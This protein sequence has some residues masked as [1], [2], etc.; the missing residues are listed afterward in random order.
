MAF[1]SWILTGCCD[2]SDSIILGVPQQD[3]PNVYVFYD[4]TS[5]DENDAA[6][7]SESIRSWFDTNSSQLGL[8]YEGVI[9]QPSNNGENYLW[10]A[11]YPYLGS[12]TGGTLSDSTPIL[13]FDDYVSG[14]TYYAGWCRA[15][16]PNSECKPKTVEFN[17]SFNTGSIY[18][19]INRGNDLSTGA[20]DPRSQGV[21]FDHT[22]LNASDRSGPGSFSGQDTN[23]IV[24]LVV[25]E[26]DGTVGYY[27]GTVDSLTPSQPSP[28]LNPDKDDLFND[29]FKLKGNGYATPST[30][31]EPTNRFEYDYE[32]YLRVWE[33]IKLNNGSLN[34]HIYPVCENQWS[35]VPFVQHSVAVVEGTTISA[36][37]FLSE[38]GQDITDVG[39]EN[40]NLSALTHTN[41]YS[42]LT[43]TTAYGNLNPTY[44]NGSGL[45]NFGFSVD[46][47]VSAFTQS[48]VAASLDEF[49][50][51]LSYD[52]GWGTIY[53]GTCYAFSQ[54]TVDPYVD[55]IPI[56][57][58]TN[59]ICLDPS[60][61]VG[62]SPTPTP[63][64]TAT[65]T[66]TPS[67]T[68]TP[69]VTPTITPT[70]TP[71]ITTSVQISPSVTPTFT[72]TKSITPT[73]SMGNVGVTGST[74]FNMFNQ[75]FDCN[76]VAKLIGCD[77]SRT[78]YVN[79]YLSYSGSPITSGDT[80]VGTIV[81]ANGTE[82]ICLYY[83]DDVSGSADSYVTEVTGIFADCSSC[84]P[85]A[86]PSPT[87]S[88]TPTM[89]VTPSVT[90]TP[91]PTPSPS[92][93]SPTPVYVYSA[94]TGPQNI[95]G[96]GTQVP[97]VTTGQTFRYGGRCWEY[98][99]QF[100][101]PYSPPSGYIYSTSATN[102]FGTPSNIY[103]NCNACASTPQPSNSPT[104]T[105]T[106]S[107]VTCRAHTVIWNWTH[108]CP[109]CD[110]VGS[111]LTVYT[112]NTTTVLSDGDTIYT[113]CSRTI[114]VASGRFIKTSQGNVFSVT[115]GGVLSLEC[116]AGYGC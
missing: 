6:D 14:S 53:T 25:D 95:M 82:S 67:M 48:V 21:P 1:D 3:N 75:P 99:G 102:L 56:S 46:P 39:P 22:D 34:G 73:P 47:T 83:D 114:P 32:A 35:K 116:V 108:Q 17:D 12:L 11:S 54:Q 7:A 9:G 16:G 111:A 45:K 52:T 37:N 101:Q 110:V 38:Y 87:P 93:N 50:S 81:S 68:A 26:A 90:T 23:Y 92:L 4:A 88:V 55:T 97:G 106:S 70:I 27:H 13:E 78:Y 74:T 112:D 8:L 5:L 84:V 115:A 104:P 36:A 10:W 85:P 94:C 33:D 76:T 109:L 60:C 79:D 86:P 64:M 103:A 72:P 43:G 41:V 107:G 19:R 31:L 30:L 15:S 40:L 29:P 49:L 113:N 91:T 89:T 62:I 61:C 80:F 28:G 51:G 77:N 18:R 42:G 100:S 96:L 66:L 2:P 71:S 24:V 98:V 59:N 44:Q 69:S 20:N 57:A 105:P 63:S 58:I 65:P